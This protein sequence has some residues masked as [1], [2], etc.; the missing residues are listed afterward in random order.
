MGNIIDF[1]EYRERN[2]IDYAIN[3]VNNQ[4]PKVRIHRE[5]SKRFKK[6]NGLN[7]IKYAGIGTLFVLGEVICTIGLGH[8]IKTGTL[9][10]YNILS[11]ASYM[12]IFIFPGLYFVQRKEINEAFKNLCYKFKEY[13]KRISNDELDIFREELEEIEER[14]HLRQQGFIM[15]D[16]KPRRR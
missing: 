1:N 3:M 7:T 16:K 8:F 4:Q 10:N 11:V 6:A 12:G 14:E 5:E 9:S 15:F 2:D 13:K